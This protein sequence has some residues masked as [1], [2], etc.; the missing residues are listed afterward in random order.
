MLRMCIGMYPTKVPLEK[1]GL[2]CW[3]AQKYH[4]LK[5]VTKTLK[6]GEHNK[7]GVDAVVCLQKIDEL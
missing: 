3:S 6:E 2:D 4:A 7:I 1:E 5:F